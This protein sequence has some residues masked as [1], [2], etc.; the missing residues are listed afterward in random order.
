MMPRED[1]MEAIF[2]DGLELLDDLTVKMNNPKRT[3]ILGPNVFRGK[4][5]R[6]AGGYVGGIWND[7]LFEGIIGNILPS[8]TVENDIITIKALPVDLLKDDWR[9]KRSFTP[10]SVYD[11][12]S[13]VI[14]EVVSRYHP[15]YK[16]QIDDSPTVPG[17][18]GPI[19][20]DET[21]I[22]FCRRMAK[23][24]GGWEFFIKANTVYFRKPNTFGAP[25]ITYKHGHN[26]ETYSLQID[27]AIMKASLRYY[28]GGAGDNK[29]EPESGEASIEEMRYSQEGRAGD[30]ERASDIRREDYLLFA[31]IDPQLADMIIRGE[32]SGPASLEQI[33][34]INAP[35]D[36][37]IISGTMATVKDMGWMDGNWYQRKIIHTFS[38]DRYKMN[39]ELTNHV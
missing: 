21:D 9:V 2:E 28:T 16:I 34:T 1:I 38:G 13:D 17:V 26:I 32:L 23:E 24:A 30:S 20:H 37:R 39:V 10:Y 18:I 36:P 29:T 22:Q 8:G 25:Q 33:L 15:Q 7:N 19:Q 3:Y 35:G 27:D 6:L 11:R 5:I 14:R 12:Y 4:K 31:G